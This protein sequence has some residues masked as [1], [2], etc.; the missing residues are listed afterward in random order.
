VTREPVPERASE[1]RQPYLHDLLAAVQAPGL[2]LAGADGDIRGPG[3]AGIY[4]GDRRALATCVLS[5]SGAELC[6]LHADFRDNHTTRTVSVLRGA[7][8]P[9]ADPTV[10]LRRSRT[11]S[12]R[13]CVERLRFESVA[14]HVVPLDVRLE[15]G[16]DLADLDRVRAGAAGATLPPVADPGGLR[17]TGPDG[18]V[19]AAAAQPPPA[20][21]GPGRLR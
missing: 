21:D 16:T 1:T 5:V 7:G 12:G 15:L 6:T 8:E 18:T 20:P 13:R 3:V 11:I 10:W 19:A 4:L 2:V 14:G 9:G 17:W